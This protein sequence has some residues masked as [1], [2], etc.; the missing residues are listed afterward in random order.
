M[1]VEQLIPILNVSSLEESFAWFE[2]VGWKKAWD[3]GDPPDFGSV[4]N[5][6]QE[7]FLCL[8]NLG[9]RGGENHYTSGVWMC[10]LLKAPEAVDE[11][12][13]QALE[14]GVIGTEPPANQPWGIRECHIKHPDGHVFRVGAPLEDE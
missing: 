6:D 13:K 7:I 4:L 14:Q 2:K 12:Y 5:D 10:W 9:C 8:N 1:K 11:F 3:W